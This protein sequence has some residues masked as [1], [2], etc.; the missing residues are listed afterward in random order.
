[1]SLEATSVFP[2]RR[3]DDAAQR[4]YVFPSDMKPRLSKTEGNTYATLLHHPL[5]FKGKTNASSRDSM[6][7]QITVGQFIELQII[8][9]ISRQ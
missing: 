9:T 2:Q 8:M 4:R 5:L 6:G 3:R 1:M 7:E